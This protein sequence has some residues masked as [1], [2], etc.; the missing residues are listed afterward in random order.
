MQQVKEVLSS[1]VYESWSTY[2][3]IFF[4]YS[5]VVL[6]FEIRMDT[7]MIPSIYYRE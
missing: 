5:H 4:F 7:F 3:N 1:A 6:Y 2:E